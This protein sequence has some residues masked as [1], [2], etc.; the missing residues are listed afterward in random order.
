VASRAGG[1][2]DKV[3]PGVNG[4]LVDPG[5]ERALAAAIGEALSDPARLGVMGAESR[6]IVE[7]EFSWR[8]ATDRLLDVYEELLTR[9]GSL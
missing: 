4:W 8:A 5:D 3:K 7:R 2:P 9:R 1:L 6:A